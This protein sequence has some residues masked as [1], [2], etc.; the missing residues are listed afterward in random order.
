MFNILL[1]IGAGLAGVAAFVFCSIYNQ[2][3]QLNIFS[4]MNAE[5]TFY[6]FIISLALLF[7]FSMSLIVLHYRENSKIGNSAIANSGG[8]AVNNTG[9]GNVNINGKG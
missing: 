5:Q 2:W 8:V 6:S 4:S 7:L 3:L 1:K 9:S